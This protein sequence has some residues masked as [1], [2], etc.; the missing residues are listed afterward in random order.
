MQGPATP[1]G[2]RASARDPLRHA[3]HR[4]DAPAAGTT[5][6][7]G[8]VLPLPGD[9][10][11]RDTRRGAF[12]RAG[13]RVWLF[14]IAL[15]CAYLLPGV[16]GHDP[17]KQDETYTFG[18]I[19]HM[20]ATGDWVVPTNAGQP[21]LEKPPIYDWTAAAFA[22]L[23]G[24]YLP[25]HDAARLASALFAALA[26]GFTA[27]AARIAT[28]APRWL[29]LRVI[30]P[31]AL[32]AGTL[33]VIKHVHDMMTDVALMAGTAIAFAA[34]LEL[35]LGR[36]KD[37]AASRFAA[38][39][40]GLGV[41]IALLAKGLFVPLVFGATLTL[42]LALYPA[43]RS[44]TFL[45]SLGVATLVLAPFALIWPIALYLRSETLFM[46]WFW[47]NNVG[48]FFGFSV[49]N[50]GAENDKP[51]FIWRALMTVGFPVGPLAAW[52]L[53][54]GRWRAWREPAVA[55]PALFGGIGM[56]VLQLS[57]TSRE[58][59]ILPFIAPLA[60]LA[61]AAPERMP[62]RVAMLWDYTNRI[63]FGAV[64]AYAWYVW[65]IVTSA[66][67]SREP[68]RWLGRWLPLD[69]V[70]PL[71]LPAAAAG[72]ALTVGW[73]WL[74]PMLRGT[75]K[76]RGVLSWAA[77]AMLAWGLIFTLLL[78]WLDAAKSYRSVFADLDTQ[79]A[80]QWNEGDCMASL[81]LG[82]SEAPM[83]EYFTG[84]EHR[85]TAK[86]D[87]TPC[88]WMIVQGLRAVT[89]KIDDEWELYWTGARPGDNEELLR[90]YVR[91]PDDTPGE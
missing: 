64:A 30:G 50:L 20:L 55:L 56:V 41:G 57:A 76:W 1:G 38:P 66:H 59:Y 83:L 86:P 81:G 39:G 19:R 15:A 14:V 85:P 87:D 65:S 77:G 58:L 73:L 6:A 33:V 8:G 12:E 80:R 2:P 90:V 51:L 34:L 61:A 28:G 36:T 60:L 54:A 22:W 21:F 75:G 74:L 29:D 32:A 68:I 23:F 84:I 42:V 88:T 69:W 72:L 4:Q 52:A 17:W 79:L 91:T 35:V 13:W 10:A 46:T 43:C 44:R 11:Q 3:V 49:P 48:R 37:R 45:R 78:P 24:R 71:G 82:E 18:I 89:P 27:R 16:L 47:D 70:V 7:L 25:L 63:V 26:F 31:V 67:A 5:A 62:R 9:A 40:L 53:V